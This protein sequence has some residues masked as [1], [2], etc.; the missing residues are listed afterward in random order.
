M[1]DDDER[2]DELGGGLLERSRQGRRK[3][4]TRVMQPTPAI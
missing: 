3:S 2:A 4:V 1:R